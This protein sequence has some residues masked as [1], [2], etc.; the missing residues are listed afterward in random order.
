MKYTCFP[1]AFADG[2]SSRFKIHLWSRHEQRP[3]SPLQSVR[4]CYKL[5]C[6]N[7][8]CCQFGFAVNLS[9]CLTSVITFNNCTWC[10]LFLSA[11]AYEVTHQLASGSASELMPTHLVMWLF[12]REELFLYVFFIFIITLF[13][14]VRYLLRLL[15]CCSCSAK[16]SHLLFLGPP[17]PLGSFF[18]CLLSYFFILISFSSVPFAVIQL[19]RFSIFLF[20][21]SQKVSWW[22]RL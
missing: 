1:F 12:F 15:L 3:P 10:W 17:S 8:L 9:F 21:A 4:P 20:Q 13:V 22:K 2:H 11:L 18:H 7:R 5:G 16:V 6:T 19:I 14:V